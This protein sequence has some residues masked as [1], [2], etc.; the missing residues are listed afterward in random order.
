MAWIRIEHG[1]LL[2][3]RSHGRS[4]FYLPGGKPEPGETAGQAL[5]REIREE[6]GVALDAATVT[7]AA[8]RRGRGRRQ[9]GGHARAHPLL[10]RG[11]HRHAGTAR[12]NRRDR[13]PHP[14]RP[15]PGQRH[16]RRSPRPPRRHRPTPAQLKVV[17]KRATVC[18]QRCSHPQRSSADSL[19][20]LAAADGQPT[21]SAGA[22]PFSVQ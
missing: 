7:P 21:G 19:Y 11:P 6:L 17:R 5:V 13:P 20:P 8:G 16:R 3:T 15:P 22:R 9:T 18:C 2:A 4:R 1:R 10:H 14:R 12:R